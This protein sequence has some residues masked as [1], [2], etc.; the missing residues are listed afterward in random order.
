MKEVMYGISGTV[1]HTL[2]CLVHHLSV[3]SLGF[4]SCF[5]EVDTFQLPLLFAQLFTF[6][7]PL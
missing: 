6:L 2:F 3:A 7:Y 5:L 4:L 1:I